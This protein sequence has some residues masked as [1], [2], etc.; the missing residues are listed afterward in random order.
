[1]PLSV[2]IT[3][4]VLAVL[5]NPVLQPSETPSMPQ[6]QSVKEYVE[7]QFADA[8]IM[9]AV[10]GCES[11]FRQFNK[12]G[13]LLKNPN[14]TAVGV[15]QIMSSIHAEQALKIG[16]DIKTLEGNVGYAKYLYE[17][18]GTKPWNASKACWSKSIH[19]AKN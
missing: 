13:E 6:A 8:P 15:L 2:G 19:L 16:H 14:S 4:A 3:V 12:D 18:Q 1:M 10:A 11:H 17:T 9:A 7:E 5:N